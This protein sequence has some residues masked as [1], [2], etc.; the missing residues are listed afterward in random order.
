M[1]D[2]TTCLVVCWWDKPPL[3]KRLNVFRI[4]GDIEF[5]KGKAR[6]VIEQT[7]SKAEIDVEQLK[8]V[9]MIEKNH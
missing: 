8:R 1:A 9:F 3:P 2:V 5:E 7:G 6:F 4:I